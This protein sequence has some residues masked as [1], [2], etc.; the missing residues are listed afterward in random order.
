MNRR[1]SA[2]IMAALLLLAVSFFFLWQRQQPKVPEMVQLCQNSAA[3]ALEE[4]RQYEESVEE[5]HYWYG[6]GEFKSFLNAFSYLREDNQQA[7]YTYCN[8]VYGYMVLRP[9]KMQQNLPLLLEALELLGRDY[10]DPNG[11]L[12]MSMLKNQLQHG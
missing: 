1:A 6:V 10:T 9:E 5:A 12:R 3:A 8:A 7:D 2:I 11:Y 4:F